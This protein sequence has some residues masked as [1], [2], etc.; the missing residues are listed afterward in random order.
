MV[1]P[2][3]SLGVI[4]LAVLLLISGCWDSHELN[5]ITLITGMALDLKE[6]ELY[7]TTVGTEPTAQGG[8]GTTTQGGGQ[9]I[10]PYS[11]FSN[12][13]A[14]LFEAARNMTLVL[15][16]RNFWSHCELIAVSEPIAREKGIKNVI[17]FFTRDHSRR[18]TARLIVS[19]DQARRIFE[20][21]PV[22][23]NNPATEILKIIQQAE[24]S[25]MGVDIPLYQFI[26]ESEGICRSGLAPLFGIKK[27][28]GKEEV[29][30]QGEEKVQLGCAVF[31]DYKLVDYLTPSETRG[32]NWLRGRVFQ[33][34]ISFSSGSSEMKDT[35]VEIAN[36]K[37]KLEPV[38]TEEGAAARVSIA[39]TA[40]LVEYLS[41]EKGVDEQVMTRLEEKCSDE[42]KREIL[43]TWERAQRELQTDVFQ[44]GSKFTAA[45]P[46]LIQIKPEEWREVF[47]NMALELDVK[48]EINET[49][50]RRSPV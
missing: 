17:E 19:R 6:G 11:I 7:L 47:L 13:G 3:K 20:V 12:R 27:F 38:L 15:P 36:V 28:E 9:A 34:A 39:I 22:L 37:T 4:L 8:G 23:S 46:Y 33:G 16:R 10:N 32:V 26:S 41:E 5:D 44:F 48:T 40:G 49:G 30:G 25:G 2:Q 35:V 45:Y 14:T 29:S 1:D 43:R 18:R 42:V 24:I 50:I 21:T 31:R